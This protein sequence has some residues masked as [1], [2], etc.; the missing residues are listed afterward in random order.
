MLFCFEFL[1]HISTQFSPAVVGALFGFSTHLAFLYT[2]GFLFTYNLFS[3]HRCRVISLHSSV[4]SLHIFS[5]KIFSSHGCSLHT[6]VFSSHISLTWFD[7]I[8]SLHN[9]TCAFF[10]TH[11][12]FLTHAGFHS[13]FSLHIYVFSLHSFIWALIFLY[14]Y[15]LY[16]ALKFFWHFFA[17]IF[18]LIF[19]SLIF[20][21]SIFG[22]IFF[23]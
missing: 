4:Y 23:T 7:A 21:A 16:Y 3:L 2:F 8:F 12:Y 19:F 9:F 14:L 20:F 5:H 13:H 10:I 15:Y 1:D 22:L 11:I 17:S 6:Y 18:G